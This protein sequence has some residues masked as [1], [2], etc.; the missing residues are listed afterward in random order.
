MK[1][2]RERFITVTLRWYDDST[3]TRDV[4]R[5]DEA[6][7]YYTNDNIHDSRSTWCSYSDDIVIDYE[8]KTYKLTYEEVKYFLPKAIE[9]KYSDTA[10]D[11]YIDLDDIIM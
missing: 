1:F 6:G 11:N 2:D 9:E 10:G 3:V 5:F 4:Y 8:G 7:I